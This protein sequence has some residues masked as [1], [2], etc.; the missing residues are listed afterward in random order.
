MKH[1]A[2]TCKFCGKKFVYADSLDRHLPGCAP[3]LRL[4]IRELIDCLEADEIELMC[5]G[6]TKLLVLQAK[7]VL[8]EQLR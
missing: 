1:Y 6:K 3:R 5:S 2:A 7:S 4:V 8:Q